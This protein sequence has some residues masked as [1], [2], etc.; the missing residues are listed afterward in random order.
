VDEGDFAG[1]GVV[2][3][4]GGGAGEAVDEMSVDEEFAAL[5]DVDGLGVR[6]GEGRGG[7][8]ELG[9]LAPGHA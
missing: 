6:L 2:E 8:G 7:G 5:G 3:A 1:L 9:E 4:E